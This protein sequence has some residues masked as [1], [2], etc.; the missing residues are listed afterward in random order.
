MGDLTGRCAVLERERAGLYMRHTGLLE[1]VWDLRAYKKATAVTAR[2]F[3]T[4]RPVK[5]DKAAA[6][7]GSSGAPTW[8][9]GGTGRMQKSRALGRFRSFLDMECTV[10]QQGGGWEVNVN[11]RYDLKAAIP[12]GIL[13]GV[14][15]ADKEEGP[16]IYMPYLPKLAQRLLQTRS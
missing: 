9:A 5:E 8:S 14:E 2:A 13:R 7:E 10:Q 1:E 4:A 3:K 16:P 12:Q 6:G 11:R 15:G